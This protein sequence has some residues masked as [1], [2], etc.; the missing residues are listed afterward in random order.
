[1]SSPPLLHSP[2]RIT[3]QLLIDLGLGTVSGAWPVFVANEPDAPDAAITVYDA[4]GGRLDGRSM[5]DG[6]PFDH[7]AVTVTVRA[8]SDA[9]G[10]P[11]AEA[12]RRALAAV[13][14]RVVT[15]SGTAYFVQNYARPR[16]V[17]TFGHPEGEG[18]RHLFNVDAL[19]CVRR[20]TC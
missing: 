14:H 6:E 5:L 18:K 13:R 4:P 20:G 10:W 17:T 16:P 1:V 19:V 8:G 9:Q 2:A 3:R 12:V 15:V 11:K 7:P